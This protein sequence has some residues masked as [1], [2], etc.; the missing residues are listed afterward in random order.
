MSAVAEKPLL[1]EQVMD[2][3]FG[4]GMHEGGTTFNL[5]ETV[6]DLLGVIAYCSALRP[7]LD[8]PQRIRLHCEGLAR[9]LTRL[10]V[11][12]REDQEETGIA[13]AVT[14]ARAH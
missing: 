12:A 7:D 11:S 5:D 1:A 10:M 14:V 6:F 8:T 4:A 2:L 13:A 3:I 9:E